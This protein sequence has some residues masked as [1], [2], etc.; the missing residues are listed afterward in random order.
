MAPGQSDMTACRVCGS[1]DVGQVLDLGRVPLANDFQPLGSSVVADRYPLEV[2]FCAACAITQLVQTVDPEVLFRHYLYTPSQSTTWVAHCAELSDWLRARTTATEP[3]VVEPASNDGCLLKAIQ[4]WAT[5][6][7]GVEPALNIAAHAAKDGVPTLPE[8]FTRSAATKIRD[9]HGPADL[10]VGTNVLAHVP[11]IVDFLEGVAALLA[12]DG[13]VVVEAPYL[14]D[15]VETLAY[16]TIYHEHVSYLTVTALNRVY[17]Q[18]GLTLTYVERIPIH[19]GSLRF[20]GQLAGRAPDPSVSALL[21][22]ERQLGYADGSAMKTFAARV[23]EL[24]VGLRSAISSLAESGASIAGYGATAKGTTLLTT[25][26]LD[27]RHIRYIVDRNPLKQGRISPGSTI[28]IVGP[29]ALTDDPVDVLL[30]LAW[31]LRAEIVAEQQSFAARG[32]RFLIPI[33]EPMII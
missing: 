27:Q 1:N 28:P 8:F 33:P 5:R 4:P 21:D 19:G 2:Q 24:R 17:R 18:A 15:L 26:G 29:E 7:L 9:Q 11:D 22:E 3:F 10:V 16:D 31:N 6:V 12:P 20:V 32:G 23:A 13:M 14:R 25:T 30:L